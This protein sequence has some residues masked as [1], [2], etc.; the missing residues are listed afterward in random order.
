MHIRRAAAVIGVLFIV[1]ALFASG[2]GAGSVKVPNVKRLSLAEARKTLADNNL[3][4]RVS[5]EL[6]DDQVPRGYV[7]EQQPRAGE[8]VDADTVVS[9]AVSAGSS[10]V[11]VPSVLGKDVDQAASELNQLGLQVRTIKV[12][13]AEPSGTVINQTP[14]AGATVTLDSKIDLTVAVNLEGKTPATTT[15]PPSISPAP[16]TTGYV[17]VIDPGHQQRANLEAEPIGP[18]ASQTK[19]KVAGGA[20]GVATH[21]PEYVVNLQ[22]SLKL[23]S[24]LQA[25]GVKV[26]MTRM[27][28]DVDISNSERA[29]IA[30]RAGA[31][32]AVRIHADGVDNNSA[33]EGIR[34]LYPAMNSWTTPIYAK[35]SL[36]ATLVEHAAAAS[37]HEKNLGTTPRGDMT[38]FNW[39]KVP[40]IIVET[41]FLSNPAEDRLLNDPASQQAIAKGI[42]QG[43]MEYL[44]RTK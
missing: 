17:V 44:R 10:G 11:T 19:P 42:G 36:A 41:G 35:S 24:V 14:G 34:T 28:N 31:D 33:M 9:L 20:T 32:L 38:G 2:C 12:T 39:S 3:R 23:R 27:T 43:V 37:S 1:I 15:P 6:L 25:K 21:K 18:G 22:I 5:S 8:L 13:S 16:K 7:V 29:Q 40:T 30:N 4:G 26:I